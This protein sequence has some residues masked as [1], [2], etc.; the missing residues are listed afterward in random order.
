V[1][2][3]DELIKQLVSEMRQSLPVTPGYPARYDYEYQRE[4]V[5]NAFILFEPLANLRSVT[6]HSQRTHLGWVFLMKDLVDVHCCTAERIA[7]VLDQLNTH[8]GAS[9]LQSA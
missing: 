4:G 7:L 5:A 1:R 9:L 2:C 3:T 8:V 6:I